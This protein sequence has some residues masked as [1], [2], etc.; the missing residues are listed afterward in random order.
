MSRYVSQAALEI[1]IKANVVRVLEKM[2]PWLF[3]TQSLYD[4][5]R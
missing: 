1:Q 2:K 3:L 5:E 4:R